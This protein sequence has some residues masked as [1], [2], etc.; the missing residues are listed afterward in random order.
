LAFL[1]T[2]HRAHARVE[3]RIRHQKDS[4]LGWLPFRDFAINPASAQLAAISADLIA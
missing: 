2:R 3:D 1:A 4:G